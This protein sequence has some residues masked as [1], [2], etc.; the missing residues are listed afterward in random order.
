VRAGRGLGRGQGV[1]AVERKPGTPEELAVAEAR[2]MEVAR[3]RSYM[4][5]LPVAVVVCEGGGFP[6]AVVV[7][8]PGSDAH[9]LATRMGRT[10]RTVATFT[11]GV[12]G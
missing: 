4:V 6:P 11:R 10:M 9:R 2:A 7:V 1:K 8:V 5:T 3:A 12:Q